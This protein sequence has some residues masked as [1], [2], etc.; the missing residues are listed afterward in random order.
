MLFILL[1][2]ATS[3]GVTNSAR[4]AEVSRVGGYIVIS[5]EDMILRLYDA[6]DSEVYNFGIACGA[7][8]GNKERPGDMK[9]PEGEFTVSQLCDASDWTHDFG[10]GKGV[11]KG[12]YGDYFIRLLTP[13]HTGI[14]IH[15]THAPRSIGSRA[16][17]GCIRLKN[18]NLRRLYPYVYLGMPV[19][20]TPSQL[21]L[22]ASAEE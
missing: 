11:I 5:K 13:P 21:D 10:D 14:G 1:S 18:K 8:Y 16:S 17:E 9:T 6:S 20:I 22:E 4:H 15:G 7:A 2:L 3:C 12:A 19:M